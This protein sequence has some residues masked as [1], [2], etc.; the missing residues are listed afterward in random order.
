MLLRL[1]SSSILCMR[2]GSSLAERLSIAA[3]N[4]TYDQKSQS[5]KRFRDNGLDGDGESFHEMFV[6]PK[7]KLRAQIQLETM[8]GRS[9]VPLNSRP[10]IMDRL[11]VRRP[12][13]EEMSTDQ[14]WSAVWPTARS[15]NAST[16]PL[17]I[18]MGSRPDPEKK[19]PFK[20][21]G[22]LELVKIPNFLHLTP[23]TI[24][25]H[26]EA[27]K[28]FC[29]E[30][31]PEL[32]HNKKLL[33]KKFPIKIGY[34]TYVHQGTNIRDNRTRVVT[35]EIDVA[36][37]KLSSRAREKMIRLSGNRF[38][39]ASNTLTIITDRCYTRKQNLEY[40]YYLLTVLY[41]ES[42]KVE[43]WESLKCSE[44]NLRVEFR[45]SKSHTNLINT[46][47]KAIQHDGLETPLKSLGVDAKQEDIANHPTM[48]QFEDM[49]E[50]YR[51]TEETVESTRNY[52][53]HIRAVLG[54]KSPMEAV[55]NK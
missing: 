29:T 16:V 38:D 37:L 24:K 1:G 13:S 18:R 23:N 54:L 43:S 36:S 17:P 21:Q 11:A 39:E 47:S 34:N 28:K 5:E 25:K 41:H 31:P 42:N 48:E 44:D 50:S 46:V 2:W 27:I 6:I 20:K 4:D 40:A 3:L 53:K 12:R 9:V 35:M 19:A 30:F 51:N 26:C 33:N 22:N 49:W 7:R 52:A 10:D 55:V 45:Q 8:T 15:F 32:A 14:D